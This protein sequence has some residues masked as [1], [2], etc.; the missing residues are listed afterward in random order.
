MEPGSD[1]AKKFFASIAKDY[2]DDV[3]LENMHRDNMLRN[4]GAGMA[5]VALTIANVWGFIDIGK[6]RVWVTIMGSVLILVW[7]VTCYC[8][9]MKHKRRVREL[10]HYRQVALNWKDGKLP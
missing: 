2:T 9:Y 8:V 4:F 6:D 1:E 5:W 10:L 7:L 3:A